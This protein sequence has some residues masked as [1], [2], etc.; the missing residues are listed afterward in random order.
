MAETLK[1]VA[2]APLVRA[3]LLLL[4]ATAALA[5][6]ATHYRAAAA[7]WSAW[8]TN[9]LNSH[10]P[11]STQKLPATPEAAHAANL[12]QYDAFAAQAKAGGVDILVLPEGGLG[13]APSESA[14]PPVGTWTRESLSKFCGRLPKKGG[15]LNSRG[16][17]G[18]ADPCAS[19][20]VGTG[21]A[22]ELSRTAK[23]HGLAIVADM[24]VA[25]SC[26][27]RE[28]P[29]PGCSATGDGRWLF[30]SLLAFE[31]D[32]SIA[33]VYHKVP[34]LLLV[35]MLVLLVLLVLTLLLVLLLLLLLLLLISPRVPHQVAHLGWL[36]RSASPRAG[37]LQEPLHI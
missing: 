24:C 26:A 3:S 18:Y 4:L 20:S 7:Q 12:K 17:G 11:T 29:Y 37:E 35:L 32:G 22:C 33:S 36:V 30:N 8:A 13:W 27:D 15:A 9:P 34:L 5:A 16:Q 21:L 19:S 28:A 10:I 2:S 31:P 14:S 1:M 23:R 25:A 6:N